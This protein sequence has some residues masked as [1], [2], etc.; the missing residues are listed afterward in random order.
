MNADTQVTAHAL[1]DAE[2]ALVVEVFRMLADQ[3]RVRLLWAMLD[4]EMSVSELAAAVAKPAPGVS[5]HLA[6]LRMAH[7]VRTRQQGN[8][9]FY[10]IE[11]S[12]VRQ[13]VQDA[14]F[15]ADHA[16]V[17]IPTHHR[18]DSDVAILNE[19]IRDSRKG[20]R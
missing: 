4:A 10:R 17:G 1:G 11:N 16:S 3:T 7:L 6:K 18:T 13:L 2:S 20:A 14:V 19:T 15:H 8:Q 12:H 9:V 5:Q